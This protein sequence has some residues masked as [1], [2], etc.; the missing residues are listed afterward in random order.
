M[1]KVN[2]VPPCFSTTSLISSKPDLLFSK[3]QN[4]KIHY[5]W[6]SLEVNENVNGWEFQIKII[7]ISMWDEIEDEFFLLYTINFMSILEMEH[8]SC[9][10]LKMQFEA[11]FYEGQ[12][13]VFYAYFI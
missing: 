7:L 1:A 6:R 13:T 9:N 3:Q 5:E 8:I 2:N 11:F 10:T 4:R 12:M